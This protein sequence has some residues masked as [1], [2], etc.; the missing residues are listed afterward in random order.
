MVVSDDASTDPAVPVVTFRLAAA[1]P[2]VRIIRQ[3]RN[4]GHAANYQA[5]LKA[6]RGEYFMW[7]A[8][9]DWIDPEYV[10]RCLA[11]LDAD[12]RNLLVC[13]QGRYY[14]DGSHVVDERPINLDS[15]RPG[16]RL[17]RYFARVSLNG[18]LFG[19]ARREQLLSTGFPRQVGGDWLLVAALA[20][21]GAIRTLPDIHIHRSLEG[22]GANAQHL[23]ESFGMRGMAA[24]QHHVVF[25]GRLWR[26]IARGTPPFDRINRPAR[27]G[28]AS[29]VAAL[30][31]VRFT[32]PALVRRALRREGA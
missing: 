12:S 30:V 8:D 13:G 27:L 32:L 2:R 3:P 7:L 20:A 21:R 1:D 31:V 24:R 18:P 4:L 22:M 19:I 17:I 10:T 29:I 11:V 6:A 14:R 5:V 9:D 25:A 16:I 23:A 28:V 26:L 15:L